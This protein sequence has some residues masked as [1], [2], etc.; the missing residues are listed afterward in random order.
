MDFALMYIPSEGIYYDL[1]VNDI[2]AVKVNTRDL[3]EYAFEKHVIIVSPTNFLAY[4]QTILQ[5]LRAL[6]I[7]ESAKE[8]RQRVEMLGRHLTA[9]SDFLERLG[10]HLTTTVNAYEGARKEFLKIDK[11]ILKIT[12]ENRQKWKLKKLTVPV[13]IHSPNIKSNP[14]K[15][16]ISIFDEFTMNQFSNKFSSFLLEGVGSLR[17]CEG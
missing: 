13:K 9:Y 14:F 3:I 5:G 10:G 11:D 17:S 8:I 16:L 6:Q 1:L 2:G 12:G 7:E 15:F 4:L